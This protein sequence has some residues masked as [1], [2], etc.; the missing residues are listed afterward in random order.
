MP[1]VT[2]KRADLGLEQ[3]GES[4]VEP[5]AP[6]V[7]V[8]GG[9]EPV[10]GGDRLDHLGVRGRRI[11]GEEA[12]DMA[13]WRRQAG[14]NVTDFRLRHAVD[15]AQ[16]K[17]VLPVRIE[18][19]TSALPRM[20]STTELRQHFWEGAPM[21]VRRLQLSRESHE[22]ARTKRR[23]GWPRRCARTS[24]A[25]RRRPAPGNLHHRGR[26]TARISAV[27]RSA[28]VNRW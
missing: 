9:V 25:A 3:V 23:N 7:A 19:T 17:M 28:V 10:G 11:V 26:R 4:A 8:I 5:L 15:M 16:T 1:V 13:A 2:H 27:T 12:H 22:R 14:V 21:A 24:S 6:R 20:R 18:L